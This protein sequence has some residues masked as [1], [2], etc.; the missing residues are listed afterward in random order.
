MNNINT[1]INSLYSAFNAP[2][3][4]VCY[5]GLHFLLSTACANRVSPTGGPEDK[6]PP[7]ILESEP[8][9]GSTNMKDKTIKLQFDE[10][11][12]LENEFEQIIIS[13]PLA[14]RPDFKL[15]GKQ[16][17]IQFKE[18]LQDSTTYTIDFGES[19]K[20]LTE[21]NPLGE[22]VYTFATGEKLDSAMVH[23]EV[24]MADTDKA[25]EKVIVGLYP[26]TPDSLFLSS[27]PLYASRTDEE[28]HFHIKHV[29]AGEYLLVAV[30]DKNGNLYYDLPNENIAFAPG[31]VTL[32]ED[33]D[34]EGHPDIQLRLFNE[35]KALPKIV[36]KN[37]RAYGRLEVFYNLPQDTL[38]VEILDK[39]Y[40][41]DSLFIHINPTKDSLNVWFND[42]AT[43]EISIILSNPIIDQV[44][45][46]T[47]KQLIERKRL[48]K[49][50]YTTNFRGG[51]GESKVDIKRPVTFNFNH[52]I[53]EI[54]LDKISLLEKDKPI[55]L[56]NIIR[57]DRDK[58]S[59]ILTIDYDWKAD[60]PYDLL[61][62]DSAL[63]DF[64]GLY[65][66]EIFRL[67]RTPLLRDYGTLMLSFPNY[68]PD[69][70]YIFQ[71][72][73]KRGKRLKTLPITEDKLTIKY[74]N[75]GEY[76]LKI[77]QDDN[78]NGL[79]DPG[80]WAEKRAAEYTFSNEKPIVIK[81]NW[82]SEVSI[83]LRPE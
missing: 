53:R 1:L 27:P 36:D 47:F 59:K 56:S 79:W 81:G 39:S 43:E 18:E 76:D 41:E 6:T 29:R 51:R 50:K 70:N 40:S 16:L 33:G 13:P 58:S 42:I 21:G 3:L 46:L 26:I 23:G 19:I 5:L 2:V 28:G 73:D 69:K 4:L 25:V 52:P 17:I 62:E 54:K 45:T 15:K 78:Q 64:Y 80:S 7:K 48:Q 72:F 35:G 71:L 34:L 61:F 10:Y 82:D 83:D 37:N 49:I 66:E 11:V 22:L 65:N 55:D 57:L 60:T 12:T 77:I 20:D 74:L 30:E 9:S 75:E 32:S 24:S 38:L 67:L 31:F 63:V 14:E 8:A 44:D 68:S